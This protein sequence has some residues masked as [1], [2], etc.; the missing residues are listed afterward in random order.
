[1]GH[2]RYRRSIGNKYFRVNLSKTGFSVTSGVPGAHVN[3]DLS[4]RRRK[5]FMNTYSLPGSGFSY[6]TDP[7]GP[8]K[9]TVQPR[10]SPPTSGGQP[11]GG[12][13]LSHD[14]GLWLFLIAIFGFMAFVTWIMHLFGFGG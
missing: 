13:G 5:M 9:Q 4:N 11:G 8:D 3:A 6:R 7:Y 12:S 1:M 10:L 2:W 14:D